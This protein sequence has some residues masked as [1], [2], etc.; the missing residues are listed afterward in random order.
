MALLAEIAPRRHVG[1]EVA[2]AVG[3]V[4]DADRRRLR[5]TDAGGRVAGDALV[6]EAVD[7]VV[8]GLVRDVGGCIA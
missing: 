5:L 3:V 2:V 6:G 8:V 7:L 1:E 4:R